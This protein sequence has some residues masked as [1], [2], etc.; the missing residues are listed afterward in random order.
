[1]NKILFIDNN[2]ILSDKL[3]PY[4][5]AEKII[6]EQFDSILDS[7]S[8][9]LSGSYCLILIN[10]SHCQEW[11]S[12]VVNIR[13]SSTVPI[14]ILAET[15]NKADAITAFRIGADEYIVKNCDP[16]LIAMQIQALVRRYIEYSGYN[17]SQ[18]NI[19]EF[20]RL[21]I[22]A[23]ER[24]VYKDNLEV[25][26]TKMEFDLL[27]LLAVNKGQTLSRE[28][29]FAKIWNYEYII[30]DNGISARIQRL[31]RKIEDNPENPNFILTV[32]GVGYKFNKDI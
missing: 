4:L 1:M 17:I 6:V 28:T 25:S 24:A 16:F 32:R 11:I 14:I 20:K 23:G 2:K 9:I 31:R 12:S 13:I 8:R 7:M 15:L 19:L 22:D 29:I 3:S 5:S 26:L 30:D 27:Y 10:I 21:I 18:K